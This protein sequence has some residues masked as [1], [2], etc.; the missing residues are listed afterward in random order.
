[1]SVSENTSKLTV[2]ISTEVNWKMNLIAHK[3]NKKLDDLLNELLTTYTD[4]FNF[5]VESTKDA[6]AIKPKK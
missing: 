2:N 5:K 6:K 3:A 1:M 4:K